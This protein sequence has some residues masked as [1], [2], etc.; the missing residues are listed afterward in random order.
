MSSYTTKD[1]YGSDDLSTEL[2]GEAPFIRKRIEMLDTVKAAENEKPWQE[3]NGHL[4]TILTRDIRFWEER[5]KEI[6]K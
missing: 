3:R 5:L 2:A 4:I 6:E 1:R